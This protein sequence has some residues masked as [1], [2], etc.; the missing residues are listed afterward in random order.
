MGLKGNSGLF[1]GTQGEKKYHRMNIQLFAEMPKTK[2]QIDHIFRDAEG[3]FKDTIESR[4]ILISVSDDRKN[5]L[6]TDEHGVEWYAQTID[7]RQVW[8]TVKKGIIQNGGVNE[9]PITFIP[10]KGL[11]KKKI[12]RRNK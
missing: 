2:A 11:K 12:K 1:K 5:Y 7:G 9:S 3:H 10:N 4:S 6:G 8:V